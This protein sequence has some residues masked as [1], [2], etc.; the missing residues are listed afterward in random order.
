MLPKT[1]LDLKGVESVDLKGVAKKEIGFERASCQVSIL[2]LTKNE[3]ESVDLKGVATCWKHI[4]GFG[5]RV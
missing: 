2:N 3:I 5:E 4:E 1:K